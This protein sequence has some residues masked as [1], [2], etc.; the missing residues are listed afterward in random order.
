M[1][2]SGNG[3]FLDLNRA[4]QKFSF[5]PFEYTY[6]PNF[7]YESTG[8]MT[9]RF[10]PKNFRLKAQYAP[11][12]FNALKNTNFDSKFVKL[13]S[14]Y[15]NE[16][17]SLLKDEIKTNIRQHVKKFNDLTKVRGVGY[18]DDLDINI[19][20][21]PGLPKKIRVT[22]KTKL[23]SDLTDQ[24]TIKQVLKNAEHSNQYLINATATHE[25]FH[26]PFLQRVCVWG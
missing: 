22:D 12:A 8:K 26:I 13:A 10:F 15:N 14:R 6:W 19:L 18:L 21:D 5:N 7:S 4:F 3:A 17:N 24:D 11:Q 1:T 20:K 9:P 25:Y 16:T 2:L 23:I